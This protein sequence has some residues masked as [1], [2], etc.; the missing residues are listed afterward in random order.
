MKRLAEL[1]KGLQRPKILDVG[2]GGGGF[3]DLIQSVYSDYGT[4]IGIDTNNRAIEAFQGRFKDERITC[5]QMDVLHMTFEQET[6][7]VVCLSNTLHHLDNIQETMDAMIHVLKQGGFLIINEMY[8]D[9]DSEAKKT[10]VL[11]HHFWA[12][13]DRFN[14]V[15][16]HE[17]L[18]RQTIVDVLD[19]LAGV[20]ALEA[21]DMTGFEEQDSEISE[22]DYR[23]LE[24]TLDQS[25][26]RVPASQNQEVYVKKADDLKKRLRDVGF[27][28]ANQLLVAMQ[29]A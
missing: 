27:D 28:S 11:M 19:K 4:I 29:K 3:V 22:E 24:K 13:V 2:T 25:V 1:L 6:F 18:K 17:T 15:T 23:Y 16:H 20:Q 26:S 14:G 8:S 7:D 9:V 12:E 10:H 21:W 5:Q